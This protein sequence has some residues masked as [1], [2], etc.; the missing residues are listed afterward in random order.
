MRREIKLTTFILFTVFLLI[1]NI[2]KSIRQHANGL[3]ARSLTYPER[4]QV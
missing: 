3:I 2:F 1:T 4:N